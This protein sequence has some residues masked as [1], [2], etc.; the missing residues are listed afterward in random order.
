MSNLQP[1]QSALLQILFASVPSGCFVQDTIPPSQSSMSSTSNTSS[2]S[3]SIFTNKG[4]AWDHVFA[5]LDEYAARTVPSPRDQSRASFLRNQNQSS[6]RRQA[7]T[8]REIETFD[9]IFEMIFEAASKHDRSKPGTEDDASSSLPSS[10]SAQVASLGAGTGATVQ[11]LFATLRRGTRGLKWT[12][13][14]DDMLD[15]KKEEIDLCTSDL[16]LLGWTQRELLGGFGDEPQLEKQSPLESGEHKPQQALEQR[17]GEQ[18]AEKQQ[19][20]TPQAEE[21][22]PPD[23]QGRESKPP[24]SNLTSIPKMQHILTYPHLIAY[25]MHTFRV[26]YKD[27]H[28]TVWLFEQVR[29]RSLISYVF[30]C[31]TQVYNELI[32]THWSCFRNLK[33]VHDALEEMV[34]NGVA[35]D[36]RTRKLVETVRHEVS[37]RNVWAEDLDNQGTEVRNMLLRLDHFISK[38]LSSRKKPS[39]ASGPKWDEWKKAPLDDIENDRWGFNQWSQS[40]DK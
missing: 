39:K 16:E 6:K 36:A 28:L 33:G 29:H 40:L 20:Q 37:D 9:E 4:S 25:L 18:Q 12:S 34:V 38:S 24:Q 27:P 17:T 2:S 32:E 23:S 11:D 31:S 19:A 26:K 13:E 35:T 22:I 1:P 8:A 10:S 3:S 21:I 14:Q 15:R 5:N 7:M 30:G